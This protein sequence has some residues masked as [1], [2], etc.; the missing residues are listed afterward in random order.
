MVHWKPSNSQI[1]N[2]ARICSQ[3]GLGLS[4]KGTGRIRPFPRQQGGLSTQGAALKRKGII[5]GLL[6]ASRVQEGDSV[7]N[8]IG[9]QTYRDTAARCP[10]PST[11][12]MSRGSI[13]WDAPRT[14]AAPPPLS[15]TQSHKPLAATCDIEKSHPAE[16]EV[17]PGTRWHSP[18]DR[19]TTINSHIQ[20]Q[21]W[22]AG[23]MNAAYP[24]SICRSFVSRSC[25]HKDKT[26]Q[27]TAPDSEILHTVWLTLLFLLFTGNP[28]CKGNT[29]LTRPRYQTEVY[30]TL[31]SPFV[32]T[33]SPDILT[34]STRKQEFM[35]VSCFSMFTI[36]FSYLQER[37]VLLQP[38]AA[39]FGSNLDKQ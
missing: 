13:P 30:R 6:G 8:A 7:L 28:G 32:T 29:I 5:E 34:E 35:Q 39:P 36:R 17:G 15:F 26:A 10:D 22:T 12:A 27:M 33:N 21:P 37:L 2:S 24:K 4:H 25:K 9:Q 16:P 1:L 19:S 18:Q 3:R 23:K 20:A 11:V 31:R 14:G 38:Y